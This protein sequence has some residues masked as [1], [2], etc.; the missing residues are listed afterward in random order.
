LAI[1]LNDKA[2]SITPILGDQF[3]DR[4]FSFTWVEL[5][6]RNVQGV[7]QFVDDIQFSIVRR[8]AVV[9]AGVPD[10]NA[11]LQEIQTI[12]SL[13]PIPVEMYGYDDGPATGEVTWRG[14]LGDNTN[15]LGSRRTLEPTPEITIGPDTALLLRVPAGSLDQTAGAS[16]SV[17][18]R[19]FYQQQPA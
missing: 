6:N 4:S 3:A 11:V 9:A 14:I 8:A 7:T 18:V 2:G 16:I 15:T 5:Q 1:L 10:S 17:S 19:G 13:G 12:K